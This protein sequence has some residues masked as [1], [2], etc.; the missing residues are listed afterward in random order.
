MALKSYNPV[1]P[2]TR[3]LVLVDKSELFEEG[4][5]VIKLG[6]RHRFSVNTQELDLTLMPRGDQLYLHLTG[7][8]FLEPLQ[9]AELEALR[10]GGRGLLR[11]VDGRPLCPG[12][13]LG[14]LAELQRCGLGRAGG[15]GRRPLRPALRVDGG[16][17]AL[18]E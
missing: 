14:G 15:F 7:T 17:R 10:D 13:P 5:N 18:H 2:S 9:N 6:P 16:G 8:E 12:I 1:T 4:G 3:A 11:R